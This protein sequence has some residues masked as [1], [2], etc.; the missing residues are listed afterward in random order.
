MIKLVLA[1]RKR[2]KRFDPKAYAELRK[3]VKETGGGYY[4]TRDTSAENATYFNNY[5]R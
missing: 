1:P 2:S 5:D 4:T 3:L